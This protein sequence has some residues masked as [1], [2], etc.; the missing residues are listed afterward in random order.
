ML[1]LETALAL[2]NIKIGPIASY[3]IQVVWE[4]LIVAQLMPFE[5]VSFRITYLN[6]QQLPSSRYK[7]AH[8]ATEVTYV[9]F[10]KQYEEEMAEIDPRLS[11]TG[12]MTSSEWKATSSTSRRITAW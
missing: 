11:T 3:V 2:F 12:T 4:R 1:A 10:L 8:R 5:R 7:S 9:E 6:L